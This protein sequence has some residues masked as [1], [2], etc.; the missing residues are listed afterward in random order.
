MG[1]MWKHEFILLLFHNLY[2]PNIIK[3][4][5]ED[6]MNRHAACMGEKEWV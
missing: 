5:K 3:K 6:E 4:I 1:M 2:S